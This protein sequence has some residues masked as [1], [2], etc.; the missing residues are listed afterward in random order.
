MPEK[1]ALGTRLVYKQN[2]TSRV[3]LSPWSNL[4]ALLTCYVMRDIFCNGSKFE[5]M[6][7]L[8]MENTSNSRRKGKIL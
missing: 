4:Q 5:I 8:S 7:K 6:L 3:T 2:F 1:R